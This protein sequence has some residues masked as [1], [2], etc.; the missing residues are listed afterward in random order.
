MRPLVKAPLIANSASPAVRRAVEG[1]RR[2]RYIGEQIAA[3]VGLSAATV[4]LIL[5]GG[6]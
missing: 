4:S 2:R 1:L 6:A 3:E 5:N